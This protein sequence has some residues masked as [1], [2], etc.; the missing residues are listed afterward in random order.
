MSEEYARWQPVVM[1][2]NRR[3]ECKCGALAVFVSG[4]LPHEPEHYNAM[5]EVD[6]WCQSCFMKMQEEEDRRL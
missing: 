3:L 4:R 6:V 5:E 1:I 2:V